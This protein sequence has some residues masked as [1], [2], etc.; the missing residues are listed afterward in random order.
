[1]AKKSNL[2]QKRAK[3][4]RVWLLLDYLGFARSKGTSPNQGTPN[5]LGTGVD[6]GSEGKAGSPAIQE[7]KCT[8]TVKANVFLG[9]DGRP[10]IVNGDLRQ[11][12]LVR[13]ERFVDYL[14]YLYELKLGRVDIPS[15]SAIRAL[16][17]VIAG[18]ALRAGSNNE[19]GVSTD[20]L[21]DVLLSVLETE[22]LREDR[23]KLKLPDLATRLNLN[24][25][26]SGYNPADLP[27]ST[28]ELSKQIRDRMEALQI[29]GIGVEFTRDNTSRYVDF[30]NLNR[31][32]E[33]HKPD[34]SQETRRGAQATG[35]PPAPPAQQAIEEEFLQAI[36]TTSG[37]SDRL[38]TGVVHPLPETPEL[39]TQ[40]ELEE[41]LVA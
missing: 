18:K 4:E 35:T 13:S 14:Y 16:Q 28:A 2:S 9:P 39:V 38:A 1:M 22:F 12:V 5:N 7:K 21:L 6:S 11:P 34:G 25:V 29:R 23:L 19:E 10:M 15:A 30:K 27:T 3:P 32:E 40:H 17:R 24:A 26:E 36:A 31:K 41:E 33:A 37:P 8:S 20:P